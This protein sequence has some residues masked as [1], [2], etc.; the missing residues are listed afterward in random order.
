MFHTRRHPAFAGLKSEDQ[1]HG[2][3][4]TTS[5][6]KRRAPQQISEHL[7]CKSRSI[8]TV[9]LSLVINSF[10]HSIFSAQRFWTSPMPIDDYRTRQQLHDLLG[11][12]PSQACLA[13]VVIHTFALPTH[14][15]FRKPCELFAPARIRATMATPTTTEPQ[16]I[17]AYLLTMVLTPHAKD[18]DHLLLELG[19]KACSRIMALTAKDPAHK[20]DERRYQGFL[21]CCSSHC[22]EV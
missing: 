11:T 2:R 9:H 16:H 18:D 4:R 8:S 19:D 21:Q 1:T 3:L 5:P 17:Q 14:S 15:T 6:Q 10:R 13:W 12:E 22:Q 7:R 20:V